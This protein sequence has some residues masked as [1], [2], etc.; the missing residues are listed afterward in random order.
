MLR[1]NQEAKRS[2]EVAQAVNGDVLIVWSGRTSTRKLDYVIFTTFPS[3]VSVQSWYVLC[4]EKSEE[5][6]LTLLAVAFV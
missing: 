3:G 1:S 6:T 2:T 4:P 5:D